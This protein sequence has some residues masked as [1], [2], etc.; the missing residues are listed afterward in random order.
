M[1]AWNSFEQMAVGPEEGQSAGGRENIFG[2]FL[3]ADVALLFHETI[4]S[5]RKPFSAV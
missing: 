3:Q 2:S 5:Q 1:V 4:L